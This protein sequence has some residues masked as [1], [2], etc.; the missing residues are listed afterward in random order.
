LGKEAKECVI[1]NRPC[2]KKVGENAWR[3]SSRKNQ[4]DTDSGGERN[5]GHFLV[6]YK[7]VLRGQG[8]QITVN[9]KKAGYGD[10]SGGDSRCERSFRGGAC[11]GKKGQLKAFLN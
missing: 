9:F 4:G 6:P 11:K 2:V 10:Y 8:E 3:K 7:H 1:Y 5:K